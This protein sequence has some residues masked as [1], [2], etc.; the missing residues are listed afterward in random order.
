MNLDIDPI[1]IISLHLG[2]RCEFSDCL[3]IFD[4]D[5]G[6]RIAHFDV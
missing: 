4:K 5:D 3:Q 1:R 6:M 2:R